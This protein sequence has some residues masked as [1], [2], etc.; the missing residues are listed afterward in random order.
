MLIL[1]SS[2]NQSLLIFFTPVCFLPISSELHLQM[3]KYVT[4]AFGCEKWYSNGCECMLV[5]I[6]V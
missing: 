3:P 1:S 4:S 5:V 6:P 2:G